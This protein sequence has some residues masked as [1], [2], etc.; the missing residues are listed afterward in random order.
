MA[1][2]NENP[3]IW[4]SYQ[5]LLPKTCACFEGRSPDQK[6]CQDEDDVSKPDGE[7]EDTAV[8]DSVASVD[9]G[10]ENSGY[11]P[12]ADNCSAE[13]ARGKK[14]KYECCTH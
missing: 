13:R 5:E 11:A 1:F 8:A 3:R 7:H 10:E 12:V 2:R 6:R 14:R 9:A 4:S